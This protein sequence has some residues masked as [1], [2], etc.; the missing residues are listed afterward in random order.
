MKTEDIRHL[1]KPGRITSHCCI[2]AA[3]CI[4]FLYV[5][6]HDYAHFLYEQLLIVPCLLFLG[7][8][9][10]NRDE[11]R[12]IQLPMLSVA[13][14]L[15]CIILQVKRDAES[16]QIDNINLFLTTYLFALPLASLL[17]DGNEKKALKQFAC[18]YLAASGILA[19]S[20]LL[21]ILGWIPDFLSEQIYWDGARLHTFWHPNIAACF[22]M[23]GI[24]F[25]TAFF[26]QVKSRWVKLGLCVLAI[27]ILVA[28]A[29]TNCRTA[30]L[31]TG[32]Y[33]GATVFF[34]AIKHGKKWFLPGVL[35]AVLVVAGLYVYAN[36]LY[37]ANNDA[38]IKKYTQQ[39][40]EYIASENAEGKASAAD[41]KISANQEETLPIKVNSKTGKVSLRTDNPQGS[42]KRDLG[43]LNSRTRIWKSAL[44][45]IRETPDILLWGM[46]DPGWYVSFYTSS[47][48]LHLHNSWMQCLV[49]LGFVGFMIAALLTLQAAW[50][51][52]VILW[53][54]HDDVWKRTV[55]LLALCL[56]AAAFLEPYLFYTD[57]FYQP[58][59][60]LFFL[61]AGYLAHWQAVYNRGILTVIRSRIPFLKK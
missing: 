7:F 4:V 55:A 11:G 2:F 36:Q 1:R 45:A 52:L 35:A 31:L 34:A 22:F 6:F 40:S 19:V 42:L 41:K 53:Q 47:P 21:L 15:W 37:Q 24:A 30:I 5:S 39:Y 29:L 50:N 49:A 8:R 51:C 48:I 28:M 16:T 57:T 60:F 32:G 54:H 18:A 9:L 3:A 38:L 46:F 56:M 59:N 25:C 13:M 61:C 14:V 27:L 23:I 43:T 12:H 33:L 10:E 44:S 17:Q 58:V 20:C 26:S